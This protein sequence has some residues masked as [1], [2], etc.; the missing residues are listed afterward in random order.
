M[1]IS[2]STD[3]FNGV[4]ASLAVKVACVVAS[5]VNLVL[6]GEQTVNGIAVV[7]GDRV[8]VMAQTV[9]AENGIYDATSTAWNRSADFD[10]NRDVTTNT[11]VL[12]E[13]DGATPIM[14]H[15]TSALPITIG[16]SS[17]VW[18]E[19]FNP[20]FPATSS[21][22]GVT[23]VGNSTDN[24]IELT[25]DAVL[26]I[27]EAAASKADQLTSGQFWVENTDPNVPK[28]TDGDGTEFNI[29][30]EGTDLDMAGAILTGPV[31]KGYSIEQADYVP[32]GTTQALVY[33]DGPVFTVDLESASGAMTLSITG[34]PT[35]GNHGQVT[36]RAQQDGA[37]AITAVWGGGDTYR[38][39]NGVA[40]PMNT[41]LDGMTIWTLE[42]FDGGTSWEVGGADYS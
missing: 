40:H 6:E 36:V 16:S 11:I 17:I 35:S 9:P 41:T 39:A 29:H 21:L 15:V 32:T 7:S 5:D 42:T 10:G 27:D 24:D 4:L 31:L 33:A 23:D 18:A 20:D 34:G 1:P 22:Q 26:F 25:G 3:R 19:L 12:A 28:Y 13:V 14:Y 2:N 37:S 8:L 30:R 38:H